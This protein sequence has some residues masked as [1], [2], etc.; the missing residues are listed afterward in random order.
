MRKKLLRSFYLSREIKSKTPVQF[1]CNVCPFPPDKVERSL[2]NVDYIA[3][4][5]WLDRKP[6][7]DLCKKSRK[8][9]KDT[10]TGSITLLIK[11][12]DGIATS[13]N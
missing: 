10:I 6:V 11:N 4:M 12:E 9:M 13:G 7:E 5:A 8:V 2:A 1:Y 3:E